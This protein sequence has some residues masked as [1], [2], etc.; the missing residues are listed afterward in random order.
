MNSNAF[1]WF[2]IPSAL[3]IETKFANF[4]IFGIPYVDFGFL[5]MHQETVSIR[6]KP[7]RRAVAHLV[8]CAHIGRGGKSLIGRALQTDEHLSI[9]G[10]YSR[11]KR[12]KAG[13]GTGGFATSPIRSATTS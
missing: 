6:P 12:W 1:I 3:I 9:V 7:E 13:E 4:G 5:K 11:S 8:P 2:G 10:L